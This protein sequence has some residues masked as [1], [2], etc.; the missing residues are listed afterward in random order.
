MMDTETRKVIAKMLVIHEQMSRKFV[1]S[2]RMK[3][4]PELEAQ[5][6]ATVSENAA[7]DQKLRMHSEFKD[8]C[9]ADETQLWS[10]KLFDQQAEHLNC[11]IEVRE[12]DREI[13][14]IVGAMLR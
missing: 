1:Y 2:R 14:R 6:E 12:R 3:D 8:I 7:D 11:V 13:D 10:M 5:H 9:M 4:L